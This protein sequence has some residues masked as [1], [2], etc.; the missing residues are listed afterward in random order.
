MT[1]PYRPYVLKFYLVTTMSDLT[2]SDLQSILQFTIALART[3]GD[4]ILEGSKAIQSVIDI[5]EKKNS[6][7]LVTE[8]DVKVE[9]LVKKKIGD[10]YPNFKL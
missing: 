7:D 1:H 8:F 6:V 10:K 5:G 4:L 9:E 2:P 3:A